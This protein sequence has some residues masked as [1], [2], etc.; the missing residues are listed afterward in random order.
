MMGTENMPLTDTKT[1][2]QCL[3]EG[4]LPVVEALRYAMQLADS[5]RKLHDAGQAHGA[6][7]P[8]N[9]ALVAGGLELLPAEEG[10]AGD[11]TPYTAPEVVQ[12]RPADARSDV[13][14]F[15]AILFE[16]LTGRRA[17]AGES[18]ITL[19]ANLTETPTP[20][21]GSPAVDRL[22]GP[23]LN[24]NPDARSCR[25]Q[26]VMMELKLLS[27]AAR[28]ADTVSG[29][30]LRRDMAVNSAAVRAEMQQLK[31]ALA[32]RLQVHEDTVSAMH[33]SAS[34]ADSAALRAEM[35]QL[36]A[37]LA[38]RLQGHENTVSE[39]H[40]SA[41]E[42]DSAVRAEMQQLDAALAAR[43]EAHENTVSEIHRSASEADSAVR[44]E[45]QQL[46]AALAARLEAHENTVSEMRSSASEAVSSLELQMAAMSSEL[47]ANRQHS[48]E[49]DEAASAVILSLVQQGFEVVN[50]RIAQVESTVE[51]MRRSVSQF[52]HGVTA[53]LVDIQQSIKMQSAS[54]ESTRTA[55]SQTD[56]LV[57]RVVEALESLQTAVLDQADGGERSSFAVN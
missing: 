15:G 8:S 22:V 34:E 27:V 47:A 17:F 4:R 42:A 48:A 39:M 21:S 50:A 49:L 38:A 24:K 11:I 31:A 25:M 2:A 14:G 1:L 54:I 30:A 28:R 57:E 23:C 53:D 32:A 29:G 40:R 5:L 56:D 7:T 51:E 37:A 18:H 55:M 35:L 45:M 36:E 16:M 41:S 12:G 3:S 44:A 13:F 10:S 52:E 6:V 43:L 20:A 26:K 33:R 46:D 19:A 9:L